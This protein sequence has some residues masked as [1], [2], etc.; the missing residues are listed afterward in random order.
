[1]W[2]EN[3]HEFAEKIVKRLRYNGIHA[4]YCWMKGQPDDHPKQDIINI[5][6]QLRLLAEQNKTEY[7]PFNIKKDK[8]ENYKIKTANKA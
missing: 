8:L 7:D 5:A 1:M 3:T 2:D 4:A 6:K